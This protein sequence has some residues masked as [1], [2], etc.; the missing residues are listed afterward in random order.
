MATDAALK[1]HAEN[2]GRWANSV[3]MA[4][5]TKQ[6]DIERAE[7][8]GM[9]ES[10]KAEMLEA[11]NATVSHLEN[12]QPTI[13]MAVAQLASEAQAELDEQAAQEQ[14]LSEVP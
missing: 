1:R 13:D 2:V 5:N 8:N 9:S 14:A 7:A 11:H 6:G 12:N 3:V 4:V 10:F